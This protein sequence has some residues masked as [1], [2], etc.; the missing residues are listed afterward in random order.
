MWHEDQTIER[1][2][3]YEELKKKYLPNG[4]D[5][6]QPVDLDAICKRLR[7]PPSEENRRPGAGAPSEDAGRAHAAASS[8]SSRS[9]SAGSSV[10]E[11][12]GRS[13][14]QVRPLPRRAGASST[15]PVEVVIEAVSR[16]RPQR[17]H[18]RRKSL[19]AKWAAELQGAAPVTFVNGCD[20]EETPQLV[21]GFRY[22]ERSYAR[23]VGTV[24]VSPMPLSH[25][26]RH[27]GLLTYRRR[28]EH[29]STSSAAI[30]ART[31]APM[32]R[33]ASVNG[34]RT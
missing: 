6:R 27:V 29:R 4:M 14:R 1:A 30:L 24:I 10:P 5:P 13:Q 19:E 17:E 28:M 26:T 22:L 20:Y 12:A 15:R 21:D 9:P 32:P 2:R 25:S 23:S 8:S 3:G 16:T 31:A 11:Q 34:P 33:C 18:K 7:R